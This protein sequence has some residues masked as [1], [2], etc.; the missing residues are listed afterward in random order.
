MLAQQTLY[1]QYAGNMLGLCYRYTKSLHD[2]EDVLQ[3]G[4]IKVFKNLQQFKNDGDLGAWIRRI[5]VNTAITYLNKHN[6]Y[7]KEMSLDGLILHPI[8][9]QEPEVQMNTK[10]LIESIRKLPA[11]YQ[12]IFNLVAVEGYSQIEIAEMLHTNINTVRSQYSRGRNMLM[13]MIEEET[14]GEKGL[15]VKS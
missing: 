4:F 15:G 13:K 11:N 9:T 5:M 7:K 14:V 1:T 10:D 8:S 3:E 12:V 2:A 6:R